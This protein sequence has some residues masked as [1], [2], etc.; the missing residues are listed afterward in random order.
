MP[1]ACVSSTRVTRRG[2]RNVALSFVR[3]PRGPVSDLAPEQ[4]PFVDHLAATHRRWVEEALEEEKQREEGAEEGGVRAQGRTMH[5]EH[6]AVAPSPRV[7]ARVRP[8]TAR[9]VV[10]E[11]EASREKCADADEDVGD[12]SHADE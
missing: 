9:S 1:P 2:G 4:G 12:A 5:S 7:E 3:R 11:R 6:D 8:R 10:R